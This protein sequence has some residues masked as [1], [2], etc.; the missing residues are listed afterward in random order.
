MYICNRK[1]LYS[2]Q[3][4][5]AEFDADTCFLNQRRRLMDT[6][7][8]LCAGR[9]GVRTPGWGK[10]SLRTTAVDARIKYPLYLFWLL[11]RYARFPL[12]HSRWQWLTKKLPLFMERWRINP[13]DLTIGLLLPRTLVVYVFQGRKYRDC[14]RGM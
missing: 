5:S 2:R 10:C 8:R 7:L 13:T 12:V 3:R 1:H 11:D 6:T 14:I 4:L 9:S